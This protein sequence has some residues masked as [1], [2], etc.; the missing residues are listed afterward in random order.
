VYANSLKLSIIRDSIQISP[1]VARTGDHYLLTGRYSRDRYTLCL[2]IEASNT[3]FWSD[4]FSSLLFL[5]STQKKREQIPVE[6]L[7][8]EEE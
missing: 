4:Q 3:R 8:E 2:L 6:M 5:S 1:V 7:V